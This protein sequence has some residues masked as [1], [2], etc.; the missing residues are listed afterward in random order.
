MESKI[1][2]LDKYVKTIK[3]N[4]DELKVGQSRPGKQAKLV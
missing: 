4:V 3:G 1:D 2:I